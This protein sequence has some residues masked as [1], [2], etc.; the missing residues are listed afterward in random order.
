MKAQ[1]NDEIKVID[2]FC[3]NLS[4][5]ALVDRIK[6]EMPDVFGINCSTHTF[7]DAINVLRDIRRELPDTILLLGGYHATFAAELI[8]KGDVPKR[9]SKK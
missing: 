3:E 8:L 2:A 5:K 1:L 9:R 6:K 7:L 4:K